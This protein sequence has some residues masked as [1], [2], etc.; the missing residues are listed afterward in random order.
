MNLANHFLLAM[1]GQLGG[2]F[3]GAIIYVCQHNPDGAFGLVVNKRSELTLAALCDEL[4]LPSPSHDHALL[5]GGPVEPGRGFILHSPEAHYE[6]SIDV[7]DHV[8]L[9]ASSDALLDIG[10]GNGPS[11]ALL[12][13]GYAGW[14]PGQ[15]DAEMST[16][17]WLSCPGDANVLF[18]TAIEQRVQKAARSLGVDFR[19]ISPQTGNA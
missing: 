15:L 7:S 18:N 16:D 17:A 14:G 9:S 12:T 5:D 2:P 11:D 1:P 10:Q 4:E 8:V 6:G 3:G 19:L 13:M